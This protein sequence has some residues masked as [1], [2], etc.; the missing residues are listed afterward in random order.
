MYRIDEVLPNE[1]ISTVEAGTNLLITG[2]PMTGKRSLALELQ[3]A[4]LKRGEAALCI[5]TDSSESLVGDL[6]VDGDALSEAPIGI[7]DCSRSDSGR[8]HRHVPEQSV[9]SPE[10]LTGIS[11]RSAK[12]REYFAARNIE[13]IRHGLYSISTLIQYL[14]LKTVFKFLHVY[15]SR[16]QE[17]G[18]FG[19]YTLD[20]TVHSQEA[21][22]TLLCEFD[23]VIELRESDDGERKLR[24]RGVSDSTRTWQSY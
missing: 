6:P 20:D 12:F 8:A 24:V 21:I 11:M 13:A 14:D 10:D 9:G 1:D 23:G 5:T 15:T 16:I 22:N 7:V 17:T 3:A 18:A 19:V 4:G 2:G